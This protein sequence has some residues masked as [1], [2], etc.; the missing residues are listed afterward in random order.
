M[1]RTLLLLPV[2]AALA[3]AACNNDDHT[4]VQNGPADPMA[5]ELKNAP[6]V[7][8][9]PS[10]AASKIYRCKDNS[11]VY[12][13]W[14]EKNGQPAGANFRTERTGTPTQLLPGADGKAPFTAAGGYSLAGTS[15]A[16][17]I[18]LERPGKGSQSCKA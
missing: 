2:A 8:L 17:S 15:A 4:I 3:L 16:S 6:P 5:N 9:P 7:E 13:D 18:T 1:N 14:L 10:I 11:L 12:L